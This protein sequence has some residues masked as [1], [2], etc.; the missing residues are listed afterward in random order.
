MKYRGTLVVIFIFYSMAEV[1]SQVGGL[2]ASKLSTLTTTTVPNS[3]VEFEP[4]IGVGFTRNM[5]NSDGALVPISAEDDSIFVGSNLFFRFTYGV[6]E[7]LEIGATVPSDVN[8]LSFGAKYFIPF[9]EKLSFGVVAGVN[10][11]IG[12]GGYRVFNKSI[13][14]L[15]YDPALA[16][17][18]IV[19]YLFNKDFSLDFD[20][21]YQYHPGA[22]DEISLNAFDVFVNSDL[23]YYFV[24]G[25]QGIIGINYSGYFTGE[26]NLGSYRVAM[27]VGATIERA[28]N[29]I[30]VF[31]FPFDIIGKNTNRYYG[32][33]LALTIMID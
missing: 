7:R 8:F 12:N 2:S 4:S 1:Y 13:N 22:K 30:L 20:T 16:F 10:A 19:S 23:G 29:F 24:N 18:V 14:H 25:I 31:S 32:F 17:G 15:E 21:Q 9:D 28:K 11:P 6:S 5:W 26:N 33:S 3:S 27:N